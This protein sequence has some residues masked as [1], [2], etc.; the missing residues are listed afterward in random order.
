M[1]SEIATIAEL[2]YPIDFDTW[3]GVCAPADTPREIVAKLNSEIVRILA[4][5]ELK[6][7]AGVLGTASGGPPSHSII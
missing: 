1:A 2:G 3:H 4:Q 6:E 7:R 5:P